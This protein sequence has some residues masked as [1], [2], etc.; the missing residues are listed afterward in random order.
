MNFLRKLFGRKTAA[1]A[2]AQTGSAAFCFPPS[3]FRLQPFSLGVL[4]RL[5][6][7]VYP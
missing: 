3:T 5:F 2:A 4:A 7:E 6:A 1:T